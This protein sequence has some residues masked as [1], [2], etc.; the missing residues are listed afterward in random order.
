M[1]ERSLADQ[2]QLALIETCRLDPRLPLLVGVSGGADSSCLLHLVAHLGWQVT[3]GHFD[4]QLRPES[5]ADGE[6]VRRLAAELGI[7]FVLGGGDVAEIARKERLSIEEAARHARYFFLFEQARAIGAQAVAVAHNADDQVETL[8]MHLLRGAGLA[9]LKGMDLYTTHAVQEGWGADLPL[10]RPLLGVK[11]AEIEAYCIETGLKP[12]L[13][14]SNADTAF[15][16]NRLRHELIPFLESYNPQVREVLLRTAEVLNGEYQ[17]VVAMVDKAWDDCAKGV[18]A[19]Y[20]AFDHLKL[21]EKPK[22]LL[23]AILRRGIEILRPGLRDIGFV[24]IDR[25]MAFV[26]APSRTRGMDLAAGLS[27]FIEDDWLYLE[28]SGKAPIPEQWLQLIAN[29]S[30]ELNP[31]EYIELSAGWRL[32]AERIRLP[33]TGVS[34]TG[35]DEAWLDAA[36]IRLPLAVRGALP[37]ERFQPF[38][39]GG[40]SQKLSDFWINRGIPRRARANWPLVM[41]GKEILWVAG[42]RSADQHS[43]TPTTREVIHLYLKKNPV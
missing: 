32:C 34:G 29:Q 18:G 9:G 12:V 24:E 21:R 10:V 17:I 30:A 27:L 8:L 2:V 6:A 31:G 3:A 33:E 36:E 19:G 4:H 22:G 38:G 35:A 16:R 11:R 15:F 7:P 40:K 5:G 1:V 41:C 39:M 42:L 43:V 23:R 13:D 37:G 25:A 20:L 14:A 26:M 28:V